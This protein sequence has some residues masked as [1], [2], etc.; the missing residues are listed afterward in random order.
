VTVDV[1][2]CGRV[3]D[4]NMTRTMQPSGTFRVRHCV[5]GVS[6]PLSL[7]RP[8]PRWIWT[9]SVETCMHLAQPRHSSSFPLGWPEPEPEPMAPIQIWRMARLTGPRPRHDRTARTAE[10]CISGPNGQWGQ[11]GQSQVAGHDSPALVLLNVLI[12]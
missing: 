7:D 2:T 5:S 6:A 9:E 8:R 3:D 4:D 1:W 12:V 11:S 10:R